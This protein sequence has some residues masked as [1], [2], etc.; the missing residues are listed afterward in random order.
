VGASPVRASSLST[1]TALGAVLFRAEDKCGEEPSGHWLGSREHV[2]S[3]HAASLRYFPGY[4]AAAAALGP[5]SLSLIPPRLAP[6]P[7][8]LGSEQDAGSPRFP[9]LMLAAAL[10]FTLMTAV[11]VACRASPQ[12]R[13]RAREKCDKKVMIV[14][15]ER[16]AGLISASREKVAAGMSRRPAYDAVMPLEPHEAM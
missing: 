8:S 2:F 4:F 12:V 14:W 6:A 1:A 5:V 15:T 7:A 9:M 10:L 3:G 16:V 11:G 13:Q